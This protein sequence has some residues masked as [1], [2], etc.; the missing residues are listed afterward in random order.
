MTS[1]ECNSLNLFLWAD[2]FAVKRCGWSSLLFSHKHIRSVANNNQNIC[3]SGS[4][5]CDV[6]IHA[7]GRHL[8]SGTMEAWEAPFSI[9]NT[10]SESLSC[11][12]REEDR[13]RATMV[14]SSSDSAFLLGFFFAG[15]PG[16][17]GPFLL[18]PP[19]SVLQGKRWSLSKLC[20]YLNAGVMIEKLFL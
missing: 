17:D 1:I 6:N 10:L 2:T 13:A 19:L 9:C 11:S 3:V 16:L 18:V 7:S 15:R 4:H 20:N 12:S 5:V 14:S 8:N